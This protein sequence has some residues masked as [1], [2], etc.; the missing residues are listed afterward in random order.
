MG[1]NTLSNGATTLLKGTLPMLNG[2]SLFSKGIVPTLNGVLPTLIG[3]AAILKGD[4]PILN[5]TLPTFKGITPM[6][7]G[8]TAI[9]N[10]EVLI[11]LVLALAAPVEYLLRLVSGR[12][13]GAI[14]KICC[15]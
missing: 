11:D 4:V 2:I 10:G 15:K 6:L 12:Y 13:E 8:A 7:N 5:G 14:F 9:D 3:I 1:G